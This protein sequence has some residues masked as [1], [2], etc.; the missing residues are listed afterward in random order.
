MEFSQ[1]IIVLLAI[2]V[3]GAALW[4]LMQRKKSTELRTRFGPEYEETVRRHGDRSRAESELAK[5]AKRVERF[6]LRNIPEQDRER[7]IAAWR[8]NQ[9]RFVDD[10]AGSIAEADNLVGEVMKARGYPVAE[11]EMRA[12]DL[13][14]DHPHVVKNYRAAHEIALRHSRGEASTEDLRNALI[15]YRELFA[16]LLHLQHAPQEV[17]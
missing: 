2:V 15:H 7:F 8:R 6:S 9:A 10:P 3:A 13:S 1:L 5:R 11:F 17:H 16:E 12:A 14:V 4:Y